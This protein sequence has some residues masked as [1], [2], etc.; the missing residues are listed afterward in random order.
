[1][2][3]FM[4]LSGTR[5]GRLVA[6]TADRTGAQVR[7]HCQCDCGNTTFIAASSLRKGNTA[8]CG[9]LGDET[10]SINFKRASIGRTSHGYARKRRTSPEY[11]I[12]NTMRSR[13]SNPNSI[14]YHLYGGRGI[15]FCARWNVFENFLADMGLRP[16]GTSLERLNNSL[17]YEPGNCKWATRLEQANNKRTTVFLTYAGR[18]R[19]LRDWARDTGIKPTTLWFRYNKGWSAEKCLTNPVRQPPARRVA[20]LSGSGL[21]QEGRPARSGSLPQIDARGR[22]PNHPDRLEA[23]SPRT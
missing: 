8:S 10:R 14:N 6:I 15:T 7:W 16:V 21:G 3:V 19:P 12:W 1:M 18:R 9:C 23:R 2:A 11:G 4:N 17:G 5:F 20:P 22:Q 13:C